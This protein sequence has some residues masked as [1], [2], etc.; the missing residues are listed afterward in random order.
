M[1]LPLILIIVI[2]FFISSCTSSQKPLIPKDTEIKGD[3]KKAVNNQTEQPK[4]ELEKD[5]YLVYDLI[6]KETFLLNKTEDYGKSCKVSAECI[7]WCEPL[8]GK[9][10]GQCSKFPKPIGCK[11]RLERAEIFDVCANLTIQG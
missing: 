10:E 8:E 7:G 11:K 9:K 2:L 6:K 4:E 3:E 1:K 5:S